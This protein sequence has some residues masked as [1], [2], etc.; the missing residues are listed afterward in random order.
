MSPEILTMAREA[1]DMFA[2]LATEL[3]ILFLVISY[4]V[5]VLQE[6]ITPEKIQSILSSRNG[7]GYV[8]AAL[9]G[10]ITPFCSCSTIP[11]LKG[12]LRA[13]A[14]FGPMM[15][16]LFSSPLL[17]PVIIGLFVVTF[18]IKVALFYF[19]IAL[20]VAVTAGFVLE[21]LGFERYV[22][23][24][25][26]EAADASSCGAT[27]GDTNTAAE[28]SSESGCCDSQA[29][30]DAQV[31]TSCGAAP[32]P[33]LVMEASG[34]GAT[35]A[36]AVA[37]SSCGTG[38]SCGTADAKAGSTESRWLR[39]WRSTWKDFKQVFPYLLLGI[40][41]G[42]F[43]YGFIPTELIAK[44]AGEGMWY[45]IPVAAIIGIPLYIR[46]EAVI[47]LSAA[48]VQ[49]GMAL[50]SVMALIIGSAG[51]SLTEVI[52]L[53]SIFKNQ[54]IAAFLTV[55]LGMAIGAGYLYSYMF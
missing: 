54:M 13:R 30:S 49:K 46:A 48:L 19:T 27:C 3:I 44:Y 29:K 39:I 55:I 26:Y 16:F 25:A 36:P 28:T 12:L 35:T 14:G 51:A 18:G 23:P 40:T 34:C 5:G 31:V 2:F 24:E 11:F 6:F 42:S 21:K 41:L 37:V 43:I 8:I 52:L 15:V 1:A 9:L 10:A 20:V 45:A 38:S 53:K 47:P 50:G 4:F 7:K 22:R 32:A 17:N 33:A